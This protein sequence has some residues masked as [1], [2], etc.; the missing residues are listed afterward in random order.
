ML[1]VPT[2]R[3]AL[4][5]AALVPVVW[6]VPAP[7]PWW[8]PVALVAVLVAV[9]AYRVP[10]PWRIGVER[11]LPGVV[12]LDATTELTWRVHNPTARPVAVAVADELAPSLGAERRR[13]SLQVPAGGRRV[14]RVTLRPAR[15]GTFRPERL[16]VR[17]T[18]PLGLGRRQAERSLP[19]RIEVHPGFRS[20]AAAELR[21]RRQ[22]ILD[23]G[24][25]AIRAR[26]GSSQFEALR[27]YV[28]GDDV[29]RIDWPAT[30][31]S[32][33]AVVRTYRAERNQQV[34]V[35]LD[36][37]RLSAGLVEDVPRLD[38][39]MDAVLAL[40]TIATRSG[41]RTALLA[42]GASVRAV[43][44]SRGDQGQLRRLS[45]AMH[46][47]EPELVESDYGEAFRGALA[48][49]PRQS[50]LVLFT[51]LGAEAV[52]EQLVPALPLLTRAHAVVVVAVRD[53]AVEALRDAPAEHAGDAYG[54]AAAV[55][56]LAARERAAD[57]LRRLGVRVVDAVPGELAGRVGDAYLEVK[58]RG[59]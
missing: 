56:V 28:E 13:A 29:R 9:D 58:A 19:G 38:H 50:T 10:A 39:A 33:H 37:G 30:A 55:S 51:E 45:S 26:G 14:E 25:R 32:G 18:G 23:E 44:P 2:Q 7:V 27:E 53:P 40:A 16:T 31:R 46:A 48:R 34:L 4:A 15:R 12:G 57:H 35:L 6:L 3:A 21:V 24:L 17:V 42:F 43:V 36:T 54:A 20:R 41:D 52:Q 1:P 22:R 11:E 5:L 47:L 49:F 59:G 8:A